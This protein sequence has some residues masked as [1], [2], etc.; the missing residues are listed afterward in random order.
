M[1]H[2]IPLPRIVEPADGAFTITADTSIIV[3]PGDERA[4]WIARY[5]ADLIGLSAGPQPPRVLVQDTPGP[6]DA[7]ALEL[8]P[9]IPGAER[10]S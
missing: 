2:I 1:R 3:A 6:P 9:S 8:D 7:I 4:V 5:L 10:T